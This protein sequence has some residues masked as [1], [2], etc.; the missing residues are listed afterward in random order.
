MCSSGYKIISPKVFWYAIV[1]SVFIS[2]FWGETWV[3]K[4]LRMARPHRISYDNGHDDASR[5]LQL[6]G[7]T[8][9]EAVPQ[10]TAQVATRC[11]REASSLRLPAQWHP[12][13]ASFHVPIATTHLQGPQ[14]SSDDVNLSL[15]FRR[16]L[17]PYVT[18]RGRGTRGR[19]SSPKHRGPALTCNARLRLLNELR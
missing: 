19:I 12:C 15:A 16:R 18:R 11:A 3:S 13:S 2:F 10:E 7:S 9:Q 1:F 17:T 6:A 5:A 14:A 4:P 8:C